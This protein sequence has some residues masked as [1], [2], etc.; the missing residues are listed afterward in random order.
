MESNDNSNVIMVTIDWHQVACIACFVTS[1]MKFVNRRVTSTLKRL[2]L[3]EK[4]WSWC[5]KKVLFT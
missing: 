3:H 4:T 5:C 1:L 2:M